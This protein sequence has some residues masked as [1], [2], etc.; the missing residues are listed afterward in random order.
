MGVLGNE[1]ADRA[2]AKAT[3]HIHPDIHIPTS[4]S[5]IV[6]RIY[7][8]AIDLWQTMADH[9]PDVT[10]KCCLT[11]II[12]HGPSVTETVRHRDN[13]EDNDGTAKPKNTDVFSGFMMGTGKRWPRKS[14][15]ARRR[16]NAYYLRRRS[17]DTSQT[18]LVTQITCL[19][20]EPI[21]LHPGGMQITPPL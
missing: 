18:Y 6:S 20:S 12:C 16:W 13:G 4:T 19:T 17:K 3:H 14:W 10:L 5:F 8:T 21:R 15:K 7:G 9:N 1:L 11:G 2:A